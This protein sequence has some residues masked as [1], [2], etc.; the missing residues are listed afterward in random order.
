[1]TDRRSILKRSF[2]AQ[3]VDKVQKRK[4]IALSCKKLFLKHHL[5]DVTVSQIA[6]EAGVGKGTI[7]EYF[8][9][10]EDIVLE[11]ITI[12]M[13]ESNT[14]KHEKLSK[15]DSTKE[16]IKVFFEFYY[17]DEHI[18]LRAI[19][20]E[21]ISIS[22]IQSCQKVIDFQT[23]CH[24]TY[25]D[26]ITQIMQEGVNKGE[27]IPQSMHLING[28]FE[29]GTGMY[30]THTI[31]HTTENLEQEINGFIDTLFTLITKHD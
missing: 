6:L 5:A 13:E 4:D 16:K 9:N 3:I 14:Q 28:I 12:L 24:Q 7:Y 17:A 18:E 8:T 22:L 23:N 30:I 20:K 15:I 29:F 27:I 1:M 21:F 10:K 25:H 11:I 2:M 31:T 19:H 26:W